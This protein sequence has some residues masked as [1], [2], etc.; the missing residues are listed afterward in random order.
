MGRGFRLAY[1]NF[2]ARARGRGKSQVRTTPTPEAPTGQPH[3]LHARSQQEACQS[4]CK[5]ASPVQ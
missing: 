1:R 2:R 3:P 4:T 5:P